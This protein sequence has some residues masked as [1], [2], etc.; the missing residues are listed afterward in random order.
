MK[1]ILV[2]I[3]FSPRSIDAL[4]VAVQIARKTGAE[5]ILLHLIDLPSDEVGMF[6]DGVPTGPAALILMNR[7]RAKFDELFKED[8]LQGVKVEDYVD[9]NKPFEGISDYAKEKDVDLIVMGS[10]GTSGLNGF[11]VG[12]NT[13]KV[14]RTSEIPVLVIKK[15]VEEFKLD[16][17][18]FASAFKDECHK[19]FSKILDFIKLF[20]PTL[21]FLRVNTVTRFLATHES[22]DLMRGFIE[23]HEKELAD[24]EHTMNVYD[25]YSVQEGIFHFADLVDADL[26][27]L[28][29]HGRQG[30]LH[31]LQDSIAEDVVN[32]ADRNILTV[33]R[34]E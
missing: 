11:F 4:K 14:V 1:R 2:P 31:F 10:H 8:F 18:V 15:P 17:V 24:L 5:I 13:E 23:P 30:L 32:K 34:F 29:T 12:S 19:C 25:D 7:A 33:K 27:A 6:V 3:D 28:T 22:K 20:D 21:H 9:F 16:N 26:I